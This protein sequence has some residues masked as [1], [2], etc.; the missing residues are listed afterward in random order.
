MGAMEKKL[1]PHVH[2]LEEEVQAIGVETSNLHHEIKV[3]HIFSHVFPDYE[4]FRTGYVKP[5]P[6]STLFI[7]GWVKCSTCG[8][9]Y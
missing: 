3:S 6:S 4:A 9:A 1:Q 8:V 5:P 2:C 7:N